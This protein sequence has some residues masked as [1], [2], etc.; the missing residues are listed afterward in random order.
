MIVEDASRFARKLMV[1]ELGILSL[2]KRGVQVLTASGDDLTDTE[3]EMKVALRQIMGA[4]AELER[5]RLVKKLRGARERKK[6]ERKQVTLDGRGKCGGRWSLREHPERQKH[7]EAARGA[8]D[9]RR[10]LL[11]IS[12]KLAEQGFTTPSGK[13]YSASAIQSM[14]G[15]EF[16]SP[17][18]GAAKDCRGE[19]E[20]ARRVGGIGLRPGGPYLPIIRQAKSKAIPGA[21]CPVARWIATRGTLRQAGLWLRGSQ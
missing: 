14:L 21:A 9:G 12:A 4:F 6:A 8:N 15:A 5:K 16:R 1:Q 17:C 7:V 18:V 3:D 10:S 13:P 19:K 11:M 2:I 20:A